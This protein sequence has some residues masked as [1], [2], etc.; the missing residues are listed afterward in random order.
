MA[1]CVAALTV[2][3]APPVAL[4]LDYWFP[5]FDAPSFAATCAHGKRIME[6]RRVSELQ[7][8]GWIKLDEGKAEEFKR[9]TAECVEI[10]RTKD[11][12]TLQ[13]EIYLSDDESEAIVLERYRDSEALLEHAANLGELGPAIFATGAAAFAAAGRYCH[14]RSPVAA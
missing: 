12:G 2:G 13:Y 8:V 4:L 5:G 11:T 14:I 3:E 10:A 9:V 6:G 7:G 1:A